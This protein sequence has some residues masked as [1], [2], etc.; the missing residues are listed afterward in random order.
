MAQTEGIAANWPNGHV[1][2]FFSGVPNPLDPTS[3]FNNGFD[4][5]AKN[6]NPKP[7][8]LVISAD[9]Y[10]RRWRTA[11]TAAIG[12]KIAIPV[13]YPFHDFITAINN[14]VGTPNINNSKALDLPKLSSPNVADQSS[15]AYYQ[16]GLQAKAF[17]NAQT[18]A[19]PKP[20]VKVINWIHNTWGPPV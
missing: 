7:T 6:V 17:L 11:F 16:L 5:L 14:Q 9:P 2:T 4:D 19:T 8:G 3:A 1:Y 18:V 12:S 20:V 13:C 15:T 10:F